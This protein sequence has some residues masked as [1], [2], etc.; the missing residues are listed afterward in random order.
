M[1]DIFSTTDKSMITNEFT[2]CK[3]NVEFNTMLEVQDINDNIKSLGFLSKIW[4]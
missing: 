2:I 4:V 1:C 3:T